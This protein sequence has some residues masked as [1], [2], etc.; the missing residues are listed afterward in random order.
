MLFRSDINLAAQSATRICILDAGRVIALGSPAE[1]LAPAVLSQVYRTP[2]EVV[3]GQS[4]A[5]SYFHIAF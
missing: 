4:G 3:T 5:V 1:V 2:I